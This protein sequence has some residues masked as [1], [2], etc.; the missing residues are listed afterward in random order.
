[1]TWME[2]KMI[3]DDFFIFEKQLKISFEDEILTVS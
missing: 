2:S 3:G 1:M